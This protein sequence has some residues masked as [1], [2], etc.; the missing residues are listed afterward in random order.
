MWE[1]CKKVRHSRCCPLVWS[2]TLQVL[3]S[4]SIY[5]VNS[6]ISICYHLHICN[7]LFDYNEWHTWNNVVILTKIGYL[8]SVHVISSLF[9]LLPYKFHPVL[10]NFRGHII[11][12]R[13]TWQQSCYHVFI[14]HLEY[15]KKELQKV[16]Q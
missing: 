6:S 16:H 2:V 14:I 11:I 10:D 3:P 12:R 1:T 9:I 4:V 13:E 5:I 7:Q 15:N 8:N